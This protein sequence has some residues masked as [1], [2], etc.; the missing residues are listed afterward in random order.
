MMTTMFGFMALPPAVAAGCAVA[1]DVRPSAAVAVNAVRPCL[2][3][4][5]FIN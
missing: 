3:S 1:Q 2:N 4:D 5:A